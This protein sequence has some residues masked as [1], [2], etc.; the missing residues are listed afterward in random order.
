VRLDLSLEG[1]LPQPPLSHLPHHL[2]QARCR[3]GAPNKGHQ[4]A[5]TKH[6]S[7]TFA[8]DGTL[9]WLLAQQLN[10]C[11]IRAPRVGWECCLHTCP[12]MPC[13]SRTCSAH[14]RCCYC[15]CRNNARCCCCHRC[16]NA[17]AVAVAATTLLLL[18]LRQCTLL[19]LPS[20]QQALQPLCCLLP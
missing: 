12:P 17:A 14:T 6:E 2:V 1:T 8:S 9:L 16:N 15:H 4:Y 5:P 7:R 13:S 20:L 19:P 3:Q 11:S 10:G 18:L